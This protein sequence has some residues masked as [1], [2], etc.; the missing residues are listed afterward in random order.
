MTEQQEQPKAETENLGT[1]ITTTQGTAV[2]APISN[3]LA[4]I[5]QKKSQ[6][7]P[8]PLFDVLSKLVGDTD[9]AIKDDGVLE[10]AVGLFEKT[11]VWAAF[12]K[13]LGQDAV[14]NI[15]GWKPALLGMRVANSK[16]PEIQHLSLGTLYHY[17]S[18][19]PVDTKTEMYYPVFIHGEEFLMDE[20]G[21]SIL[22][23]KSV[24]YSSAQEA[25][26]PGYEYQN[27]IYFVNK[28]FTDVFVLSAKNAGHKYTT[29][30]LRPYMY[31]NYSKGM[32]FDLALLSKWVTFSTVLHKNKTGTRQNHYTNLVFSDTAVTGDEARVIKALQRLLFDNFA[33]VLAGESQPITGAVAAEDLQVHTTTAADG[34]DYTNL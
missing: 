9:D 21:N 8:E 3:R 11:G 34:S 4:G 20:S 2:A 1:E 25:K 31:P 30:L 29:A 13:S 17:A 33:K 19:Q 18:K 26:T 27:S 6:Q 15:D 10:R 12:M 14:D 23:R 7:G 16:G 22:E 32:V 5:M 24:P 28:N